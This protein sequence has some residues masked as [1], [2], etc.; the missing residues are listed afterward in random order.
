VSLGHLVLSIGLAA[1]ITTGIYQMA[2]KC[3]SHPH[4]SRALLLR[5]SAATAATH[6][7]YALL[8]PRAT[9]ANAVGLLDQAA[10]QL[11]LRS[12][13]W[14]A[15]PVDSPPLL[16]A[17][18]LVVVDQV[19]WAVRL[20]PHGAG[21]QAASVAAHVPRLIGL[22]T[23]LVWPVPGGV[24]LTLAVAA[25][26]LPLSV[27]AAAGGG[28]SSGPLAAPGSPAVASNAS[29]AEPTGR[30]QLQRRIG[31]MGHGPLAQASGGAAR[32]EAQ[33]EMIDG[34]QH[35]P[36][37]ALGPIHHPRQMQ[38]RVLRVIRRLGGKLGLDLEPSIP[39]RDRLI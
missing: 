14:P 36:T 22:L 15:V 23:L 10:L 20:L 34:V 12:R 13:A 3:E 26:P 18:A 30:V 8:D 35:N 33:E 39:V 24:L 6:V 4:Q 17:A 31:G 1:C 11:V 27:K 16:T 19:V 5:I 29:A 38:G 32:D 37:A 7:V 21:A 9:A 2:K 25:D 28:G